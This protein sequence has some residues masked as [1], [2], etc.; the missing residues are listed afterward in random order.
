[1]R[2]QEFSGARRQK[3]LI[4][5][6]TKD[7]LNSWKR[8]LEN[9]KAQ[10]INIQDSGALQEPFTRWAKRHFKGVEVT[11]Q[12]NVDLSSRSALTSFIKQKVGNWL[13]VTGGPGGNTAKKAVDQKSG[14][15]QQ[16]KSDD[17][18]GGQA[19]VPSEQSAATNNLKS[20]LSNA[21]IARGGLNRDILQAFVISQG[22]GR[23]YPEI[24]SGVQ[25]SGS[26]VVS[27]DELKSV[28]QKMS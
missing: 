22:Y 28:L 12:E 3:G 13:S 14:D 17:G 7:T 21:R 16:Q 20:F 10:N 23:N 2:L 1:M 8:E 25:S 15:A 4:N 18:I 11:G 5:K 19:E 26:K 9:L 6:L 24:M 27:R